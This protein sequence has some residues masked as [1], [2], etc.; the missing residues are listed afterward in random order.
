MASAV[1]LLLFIM[2]IC[3]FLSF[4]FFVV[5]VHNSNLLVGTPPPIDI[6][7]DRDK[8][9]TQSLSFPTFAWMYFS[10]QAGCLS[11]ELSSGCDDVSTYVHVSG[12]RAGDQGLT[13][14]SCS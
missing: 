7:V 8:M 9:D 2:L 1:W 6:G 5:V 10:L 3:R 14:G 4:I 12:A 11:V 13:V